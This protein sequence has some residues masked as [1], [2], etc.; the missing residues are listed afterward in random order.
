MN[1]NFEIQIECLRNQ[2]IE[3]A[4]NEGM[5]SERTIIL[6]RELDLLINEYERQK[7]KSFE[8]NL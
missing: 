7:E 6:S 1:C 5:H 8:K 2:L 4:Q 3:V